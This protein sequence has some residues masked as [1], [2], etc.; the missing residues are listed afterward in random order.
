MID[1]DK[2]KAK[3]L[4][5]HN[6]CWIW[7]RAL[8]GGKYRY[9]WVTYKNKQMNAHRLSW[10]LFVGELPEKM[11]VCHK[12]D[13]PGCV[14]PSHLFLG[15]HADNMRDMAI[16]GRAAPMIKH[17]RADGTYPWGKLTAA[18]INWARVA[19]KEPSMTHKKIAK[20]L[21]CHRTAIGQIIRGVTHKN[22]V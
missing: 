17:Q 22:V 21:N 19:S 14:N 13:V 2:F 7:Q 1:Q 20:I 18:Q 9:G 5:D 12:C 3:T 8:K 11:Y 15:T 16:K 4:V 10:L 6:G